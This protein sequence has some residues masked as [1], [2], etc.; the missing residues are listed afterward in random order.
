MAARADP[1]EVNSRL[2]SK[3]PRYGGDE[4]KWEDWAFC[5]RAYLATMADGADIW[6]ETAERHATPVLN[7]A[8][9][10]EARGFSTQLYYVLAM[11]LHGSALVTLK[12]VDRGQG[13]EAWRCLCQR[14]DRPAAG[15]VHALLQEILHPKAFPADAAGFETALGTWEQ[16]VAKWEALSADILNDAIKRQ[17]LLE[18]APAG[19]RVHL[20]LQAHGSYLSL[21]QALTEYI[22]NARDW[23]AASLPAKA[24]HP[25][26]APQAMEVDAIAKGGHGKGDKGGKRKAVGYSQRR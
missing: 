9:T 24:S 12:R 21:R 10:P 22:I 16:K 14:Y 20:T 11:L 4:E 15:R 6:T 26:Q 2:L 7:A 3:P 23:A 19:I 13:L 1:L 8:L 25:A 5:M 18:Q 17:V